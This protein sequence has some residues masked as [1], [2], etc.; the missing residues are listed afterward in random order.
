MQSIFCLWRIFISFAS[1]KQQ[2]QIKTFIH[3]SRC[4]LWKMASDSFYG[5]S[6]NTSPPPPFTTRTFPS[7]PF[8]PF[9][10]IDTVEVSCSESGLSLFPPLNSPPCSV[11]LC[12]S[13]LVFFASKFWKKDFL[14]LS[15]SWK[16]PL[17]FFELCSDLSTLLKNYF[18]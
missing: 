4:N 10:S 13:K 14:S 3:S 18:L 8:F 11:F 6:N 5:F 1:S 12:C 16:N 15:L 2:Q 9:I 17:C 7:P